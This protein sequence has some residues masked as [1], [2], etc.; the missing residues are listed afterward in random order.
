M[1]VEEGDVLV[2]DH[3]SA[4]WIKRRFVLEVCILC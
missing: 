2:L 1:M 3:A 4:E